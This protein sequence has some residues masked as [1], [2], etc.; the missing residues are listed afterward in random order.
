VTTLYLLAEAAVLDGEL[1]QALL[2]F[3]K[4]IELFSDGSNTVPTIYCRLGDTLMRLRRYSEAQ[5][6]YQTILD[7]DGDYAPAWVGLSRLA[8]KLG[9]M[10]DAVDNATHAVSLMHVYPEAHLRLGEALIAAN[11]VEDAVTALEVCAIQSPGLYRCN[12]L[13]AKLK[14]QL[15]H[16]DAQIYA[17]RAKAIRLLRQGYG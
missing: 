16:T 17:S 3:Q 12:A 13:L 8:Y 15:G 9:N 4:A 14:Q 7:I 1:E 10:E 5:H 11:R 2:L 6:A